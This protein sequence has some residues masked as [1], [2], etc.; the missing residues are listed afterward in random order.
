MLCAFCL[1]LVA[2][3][4]LKTIG[5]QLLVSGNGKLLDVEDLAALTR[6]G[7]SVVLINNGNTLV[8]TAILIQDTSCFGYG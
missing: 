2:V 3:Q 1:W 4:Q 6:V 7:G 5:G 8:R